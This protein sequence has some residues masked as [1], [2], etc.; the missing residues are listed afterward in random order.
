[1]SYKQGQDIMLAFDRHMGGVITKASERHNDTEALLLARAAQI[2]RRDIFS[3]HNKLFD[4]TFFSHMIVRP[5]VY[6]FL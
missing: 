1:M 4:G 3:N 5:K 2:I 6:L